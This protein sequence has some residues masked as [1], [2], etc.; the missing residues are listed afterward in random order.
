MMDAAEG[1]GINSARAMKVAA[2]YRQRKAEQAAKEARFAR[3]A[4]KWA[5][6]AKVYERMKAKREEALNRA[7]AG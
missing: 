5:I 1:T 3:D 6:M 4:K 2:H 7:T